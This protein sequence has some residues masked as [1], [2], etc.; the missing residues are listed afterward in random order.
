MTLSL[1]LPWPSRILHPNAR[2]NRHAKA[3]A[4]KKARADAGWCAKAAGLP[5]LKAKALLVTL[6][7]TPPDRRPRDRD[8]MLASMKPAID[9]IAD[10]IGV[11]D[12]KWDFVIRTTDPRPLGNVRIEIE[13][14]A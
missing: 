8:G 1:D 2:P 12:S 14:A 7:F 9:G 5:T 4:A 3:K 10:V 11:D 6:V 13:V